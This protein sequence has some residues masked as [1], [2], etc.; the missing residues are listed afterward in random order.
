LKLQEIISTEKHCDFN[1]NNVISLSPGKWV[2]TFPL[3]DR[4]FGI[5]FL[6]GAPPLVIIDFWGGF[7]RIR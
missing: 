7:P 2:T 4:K 6:G 3:F 5:R 1:S